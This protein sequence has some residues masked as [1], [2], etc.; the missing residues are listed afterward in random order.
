MLT[1]EFIN[2]LDQL[3]GSFKTLSVYAFLCSIAE[4]KCVISLNKISKLIHIGRPR[5]ITMLE[6]LK[7]I[8]LLDFETTRL[9]T[10]LVIP[11]TT[12]IS[13]ITTERTVSTKKISYIASQGQKVLLKEEISDNELGKNPEAL[14]T[15]DVQ[16]LILTGS[17]IF[18]KSGLAASASSAH[19]HVKG[20]RDLDSSSLS[21]IGNR[22]KLVVTSP[23]TGSPE[24]RPLVRG[25][26]TKNQDAAEF[27]PQELKLSSAWL[28]YALKEMRFT[29]PPPDWTSESFASALG[30]VRKETEYTIE[31]TWE[32]LR[33]VRYHKKFWQ[34]VAVNP[35]TLLNLSRKTGLRIID[36]IVQD[37][38]PE[39][40]RQKERMETWDRPLTDEEIANPWSIKD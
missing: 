29:K 12:T 5:L 24:A 19:T 4:T 33:F 10:K 9:G 35:N 28:E 16:R 27:T 36:L 7:K 23:I 31:Q 39:W 20:S 11:N 3:N 14:E 6:D 26:L 40:V 22:G 37:M 30:N 32:I 8:G 13:F 34:K 17:R 2:L 38:K 25:S 21:Q 1:P 15:E 18:L